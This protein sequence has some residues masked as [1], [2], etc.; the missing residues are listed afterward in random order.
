MFVLLSGHSYKIELS[1]YLGRIG[2][3]IHS[4]M[5]LTRVTMESVAKQIGQSIQGLGV[6][7]N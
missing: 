2:G 4:T 3:F 1:A 5:P 6:Q 7:N